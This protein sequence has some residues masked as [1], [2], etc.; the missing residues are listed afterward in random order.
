MCTIACIIYSALHAVAFSQK[1]WDDSWGKVPAFKHINQ[2]ALTC[3]V[4]VRGT[5]GSSIRF[6]PCVRMHFVSPKK[7]RVGS[8][9]FGQFGDSQKPRFAFQPRGVPIFKKQQVTQVSKSDPPRP[10]ASWIP[11]ESPRSPGSAPLRWSVHPKRPW[12]R[13]SP[14]HPTGQCRNTLLQTSH[15]VLI[16]VLRCTLLKCNITME[17]CHL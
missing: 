5:F 3:L 10:G 15:A 4:I 8:Q 17:N 9:N 1:Y 14:W 6:Y 11:G 7:I 2:Y 12:S 16:V 13:D